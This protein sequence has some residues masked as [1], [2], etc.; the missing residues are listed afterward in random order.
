[1][2]SCK[3]C[4]VRFPVRMMIDGKYRNMQHRKY[5]VTCSPFRGNNRRKLERPWLGP[6]VKICLLCDKATGTRYKR[7][8]TCYSRIRRYKTKCALVKLLG[9]KCAD[10]G[11]TGDPTVFDFHHAD[12]NKEFGVGMECNRAWG[13]VKAEA[14]KCT[15]LCANCHRMKHIG[16]RDKR[17]LDAVAEYSGTYI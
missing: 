6:K 17:F 1:M 10:C 9:G 16:V 7:C 8:G 5:C 11:W 14:L 3:K 4:F 15:L 2:P 13:A 12:K